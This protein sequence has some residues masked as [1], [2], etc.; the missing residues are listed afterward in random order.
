MARIGLG[1][2]GAAIGG[3]IGG[4]LGAKVGGFIGSTLG[5][6]VDNR[7]FG[8]SQTVEGP[9]VEDLRVQAST[10]GGVIPLVYGAQNRMAGNVIWTTGLIETV[11]EERQGKGGPSVSTVSY[12]YRL[13]VAIAFS[14]REITQVKKLLANGEVIFDAGSS[15][16]STF[17]KADGTH[18]VFETLRIYHGD[19]TQ[20]PD[21]TIESYE[22]VGEVPAY[23]G[24]AYI[25]IED[26]QLAD[27]GNRLPNIE[28]IIE[29]DTSISVAETAVDIA[30]R[31]GI[32]PL[33]MST[34]EI[35]ED[36]PGFIVQS[37]MTGHQA[38]Q[39]LG[40]VYNFDTAEVWG[41]LRLQRRGL[42]PAG[43]IEQTDLA[44]HDAAQQRP[45]AIRWTR[46]TEN[47]LPQEAVIRYPDPARDYQPNS[48][49]SR[50]S[51]G[52]A[53]NN[54]SADVA[55]PITADLARAVSDR[56]L[57]DARV[58]RQEA[59][60]S[61]TDRWLNLD[62]GRDYLVKTDQG[63]ER[64]RVTSRLRGHNGV[65]R[66]MLRRDRRETYTG[67]MPGASPL[68][69]ANVVE[70]PGDTNAVLMDIPI[71]RDEDDDTGFYW[72]VEGVEPGWRGMELQRSTDGGTSYESVDLTSREAVLADVSGTP[73]A[74]PTTVWDR[75]TVI[76]VT[77]DD[78]DQVLNS[79]S[80]L[81]VLNGQNVA[82]I[83]NANGQGGEV[84]QY[85]TATMTA[86]GVYELTDLLR[87]RLGTEHAVGTH[88]AGE[89]FVTLRSGFLRRDDF[90]ASDWNKSRLYRP[91]SSLQTESDAATQSFTNTGEGKRPLSMTHPAG[92]RDGSN[93]LTLTAV[94]RSRYRQPGL[95]N[96]LLP[97]GEAAA[98][99]EVDILVGSTVVRTL[100]NSIPSVEYTAAQQTADGIT[101]GD[102]VSGVWYQVSDVR[103][104]GH[105]LEFTV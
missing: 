20:T 33:E 69:P 84:F 65:G 24:T 43:V 90:G 75:A 77:L 97:L 31:C 70:L 15:S 37:P 58:G 71:L 51:T 40:L 7:L 44:A 98:L 66:L 102:P 59:Q 39:P 35:T 99:Y 79:I 88:G 25:V 11:T 18:A 45:E 42:A 29:A 94:R 50:A 67:V 34:S 48:Q 104:R 89:R 53:R 1:Y 100:S 63:L 6:M 101:P 86:P 26:L 52:S 8:S 73:P 60:G 27:F 91:V 10:Y 103:G 78:Q 83:G 85:A 64:V 2:A 95:G 61:V 36:L 62:I 4:P 68:V 28:A 9:R 74:G 17:T 93:N 3:L 49:S 14:G 41:T 81:A 12:S 56:M 46:A 30:E 16:A 92:T 105:P 38:M 96:G 80:E 55:I 22:G 32:N 82:W 13:S 19:F 57:W 21:P 47:E 5:G 54:L 23:R 76:T 87:G 72:A